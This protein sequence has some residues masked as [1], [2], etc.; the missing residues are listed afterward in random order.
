MFMAQVVN[1]STTCAVKKL[2]LMK[3]LPENNVIPGYFTGALFKGKIRLFFSSIS[4][5]MIF[6]NSG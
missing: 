1:N 5:G 2:Y 4:L 3:M 6:L